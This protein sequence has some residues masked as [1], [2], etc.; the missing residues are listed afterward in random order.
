[1][2]ISFQDE[3]LDILD[4][5]NELDKLT[6]RSWNR[7]R[8]DRTMRKII[9]LVN[10]HLKNTKVVGPNIYVQGVPTEF[11]ALIVKADVEPHLGVYASSDILAILEIKK[12]GFFFRKIE[13]EYKI[14]ESFHA[15][16][17]TQIPFFYITIKESKKFIEATRSILGD[18]A[19]F[20]CQSP[21]GPI[22]TGEWQRFVERLLRL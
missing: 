19:F 10:R 6:G 14:R 22:I 21:Q 3:Q 15:F 4:D 12:H 11:D 2:E 18:N 9:V 16:Y 13:G 8:G 20:L 17:N 1:M 5:S 7:F